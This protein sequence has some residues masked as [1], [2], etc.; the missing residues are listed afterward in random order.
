MSIL[1]EKEYLKKLGSDGIKHSIGKPFSDFYCGS[2]LS[3]IGAIFSLMQPPPA[4]ILDMG[5]G[6]GWTSRF[7]A[8]RGY[9]VVGVDVSE[10]M[11]RYANQIKC[12]HSLDNLHFE[13]KNFEDIEYVNQFNYIIF[14]DSLHHSIQSQLVMD[15]AFKA[16]K[17]GGSLIASEPGR[18]HSKTENS[19][20][21]VEKYDV[22]EKDM[23]PNLIIRMGKKSGFK[24]SSVYPRAD[25]LNMLLYISDYNKIP[26]NPFYKKLL[27]FQ[28]VRAAAALL[29]LTFYKLNIG[30][31]ILKKQ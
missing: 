15:R 23:P 10:D 25:A 12:E 3:E 20:K 14:F 29:I 5:C 13:C 4:R 24:Q 21:A 17:P 6:T 9:E 28:I 18:G 22:T 11:I 16:L 31:V 2:M 19:I 1:G 8:E 27:K 30:I 7:F 26:V